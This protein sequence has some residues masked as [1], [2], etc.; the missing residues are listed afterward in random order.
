MILAAEGNDYGSLN[1]LV[2]A[3]TTIVSVAVTIGAL[4]WIRPKLADVNEQLVKAGEVVLT[5]VGI[6]L[7]W[8]QLSEPSSEPSLL[9]VVRF[10]IAVFI[11]SLISVVVLGIIS[12]LKRDVGTNSETS[13]VGGFWLTNTGRHAL[14]TQGSNQE[15]YAACA[16][17]PEVMWPLSSHLLAQGLFLIFDL[18]VAVAG[19]V[20]IAGAAMLLMMHQM[21]RILEFSVEPTTVE[22]NGTVTVHWRVSSNADT[23]QIDP[24]GDG[25]MGNPGSRPVTVGKETTFKLIAK[26]KFGTRSVEQGVTVHPATAPTIASKPLPKQ[27][28]NKA[29][30]Q[31]H[32]PITAPNIVIE[33]RTCA[34]IENVVIRGSGWLETERDKDS[35]SESRAD[36]S[37]SFP[38]SGR[39]EMFVTYASAENRSVRVTL[40]KKIIEE[41]AL[42]APTGGSAEPNE[43]EQS[44]G[45]V[46]VNGGSNIV[47]FF[48]ERPFP[49][50][51]RIRFRPSS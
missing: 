44:L 48:S 29:Q 36:C 15:A 39:Y 12:A 22:T 5:A 8:T 16:F 43:I 30:R 47:E 24:F 46:Q 19:S 2:Q 27:G 50:I 34:L 3:A 31:V 32:Q 28:K 18:A 49:H 26:N 13:E 41:N 4:W 42:A 35:T 6:V 17:Q 10:L 1:G 40:N 38:A 9:K 11:V 37:V 25:N 7:L 51:Q 33:A 45:V 14:A 21:P 20:L 23:V